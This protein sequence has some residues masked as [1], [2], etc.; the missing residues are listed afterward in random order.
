MGEDAALH[1]GVKFTLDRGRQAGG[2]GG[3]VERSEDG[4]EMVGNHVIQ[5]CVARIAWFVGSNSWRHAS[6]LRTASRGGR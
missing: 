6:T 1:I 4:F 2:I 3:G 5:D